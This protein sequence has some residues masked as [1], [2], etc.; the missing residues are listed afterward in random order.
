[1][2]K[3]KIN[4][5][6][7]KTACSIYHTLIESN[8]L[9][10]KYLKNHKVALDSSIVVLCSGNIIIKKTITPFLEAEFYAQIQLF[11]MIQFLFIIRSL[12]AYHW[13]LISEQL[14]YASGR[15]LKKHNSDSFGTNDHYI[16][17]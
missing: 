6:Y 5:P 11:W 4:L 12:T 7:Q 3:F 2:A 17:S 9:I 14:G 10:I 13:S 16:L 1:M 8:P 15:Q